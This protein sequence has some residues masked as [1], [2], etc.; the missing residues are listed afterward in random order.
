MFFTLGGGIRNHVPFLGK[1]LNLAVV[2]F[3]QCSCF[4]S[5]L[6][7]DG[8]CFCGVGYFDVVSAFFGLEY[9]VLRASHHGMGSIFDCGI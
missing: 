1:A 7:F 2:A 3:L 9:I 4:I 6:T 8:L 5:S